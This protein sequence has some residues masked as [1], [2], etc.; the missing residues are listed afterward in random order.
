MVT[1]GWHL[2]ARHGHSTQLA[3]RPSPWRWTPTSWQLKTPTNLE[4]RPLAGT[5]G[6]RLW[7]SSSSSAVCMHSSIPPLPSFQLCLCR[8]RCFHSHRLQLWHWRPQ[9]QPVSVFSSRLCA[10]GVISR[11]VLPCKMSRSSMLMAGVL[12]Q[13]S[14]H[15]S[16]CQT[17]SEVSSWPRLFCACVHSCRWPVDNRVMCAF[18]CFWMC[19]WSDFPAWRDILTHSCGFALSSALTINHCVFVVPFWPSGR[20]SDTIS[21]HILQIRLMRLIQLF[22][23]SC[24]SHFLSPHLPISLLRYRHLSAGEAAVSVHRAGQSQP[25]GHRGSTRQCQQ[26][27]GVG[28]EVSWQ[29]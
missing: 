10:P 16:A 20:P 26:S 17:F 9:P 29:G 2:E 22:C 27:P 23:P 13:H 3:S 1:Y 6:N 11:N 5:R 14:I 24:P 28:A 19:L 21:N 25:A 7:H 15:V 4:V 12:W 18:V 8:V